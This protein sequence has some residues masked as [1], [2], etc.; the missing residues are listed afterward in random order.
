MGEDI[1]SPG[2]L[3]LGY[4]DWCE[5]ISKHR[6][7]LMGDDDG[8]WLAAWELLDLAL[9]PMD[10]DRRRYMRYGHHLGWVSAKKSEAW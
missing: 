9:S 4:T 5:H 6:A 10:D 7:E 1:L 2:N 8:D 3:M